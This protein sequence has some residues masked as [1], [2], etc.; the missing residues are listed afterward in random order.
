M[1]NQPV[2]GFSAANGSLYSNHPYS[3]LSYANE[4][5]CIYDEVSNYTS[6][7]FKISTA[8]SPIQIQRQSCWRWYFN[9]I[10]IFGSLIQ[11]FYQFVP[12]CPCTGF[13]ASFDLRW[14]FAGQNSIQSCYISDVQ[15]YELGQ[16]CCYYTSSAISGAPIVNGRFSGGFLF[17]HPFANFTRYDIHDRAPKDVCCSVGL[18]NIFQQRRPL[19]SCSENYQT[20]KLSKHYICTCNLS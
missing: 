15:P 1:W 16:L 8:P 10:R 12:P 3:F 18:C 20:G 19:Q 5:A 6:V 7:I 11:F 17:F 13:Q 2:I 9:D 4:I 14:N